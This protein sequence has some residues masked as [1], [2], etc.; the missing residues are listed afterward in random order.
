MEGLWGSGRQL[1]HSLVQEA[2][3]A[4]G[5][6]VQLRVGELCAAPQRSG[7]MHVHWCCSRMFAGGQS[8]AGVASW[9]MAWYRKPCR[10]CVV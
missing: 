7:A 2:P 6:L 4:L 5:G 9:P 8:Q 10:H 1:A 3:Q